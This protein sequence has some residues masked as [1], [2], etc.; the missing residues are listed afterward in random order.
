MRLIRRIPTIPPS[1]VYCITRKKPSWLH[2]P[3]E[4]RAKARCVFLANELPSFVDRSNGLWDR[5]IILPFTHRF[6]DTDSEKPNLKYELEA[7]LP[8]IFNWSIEGARK[9]ET[10]VRFP[11]PQ[12]S[13]EYLARHRLAC[14]HEAAFLRENVIAVPDGFCP[15]QDLYQA[16]RQWTED[17]GYKSFGADR[18]NAAVKA[19]FPDVQEKRQRTPYD[20]KVWGGICFSAVTLT[21]KE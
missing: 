9:L 11:V 1:T 7:E 14:D 20:R 18:F 5:L 12:V 3:Q 2:S 6:R 19:A 13:E 16:Y 17:H 21:E 8:G 10:M 4:K 15:K